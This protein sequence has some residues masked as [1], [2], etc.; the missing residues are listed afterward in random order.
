MASKS[1]AAIS[2]ILGI[3]PTPSSSTASGSGTPSG[4]LTSPDDKLTLETLTTST[5]SVADYF[6]DKLLAKSSAKSGT[7][8]P[9]TPLTEYEADAHDAPRGGLGSFRPTSNMPK[10]FS[11][12]PPTLSA[13]KNRI[14]VHEPPS[15]I[16]SVAQVKS[17]SEDIALTDP[18]PN[19]KK[20]KRRKE[21]D[22][23]VR[24]DKLSAGET[25]EGQKRMKSNGKTRKDKKCSQDN[26]C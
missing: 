19:A 22:P 16:L 5:K 3:A 13:Q 9:L 12:I 8:T 17:T 24:P 14:S 26:S 4:K 6:R 20:K 23:S 1:T 18:S 2:E 25:N 11:S 21:K 10:L 7:P 15:D